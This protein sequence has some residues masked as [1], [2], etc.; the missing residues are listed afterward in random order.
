[1]IETSGEHPAGVEHSPVPPAG[2]PFD[3]PDEP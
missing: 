3:Y 2:I 1:M